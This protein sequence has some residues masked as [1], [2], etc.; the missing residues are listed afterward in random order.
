MEKQLI[1][2]AERFTP[3]SVIILTKILLACSNNYIFIYTIMHYDATE[4]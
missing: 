2:N 3:I 4:V 1:L